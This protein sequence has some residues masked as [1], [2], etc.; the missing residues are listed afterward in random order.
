MSENVPSGGLAVTGGSRGLANI[1][2]SP[3]GVRSFLETWTGIR[4][5]SGPVSVRYFRFMCGAT[6]TSAEDIAEN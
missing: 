5:C 3:E 6:M 4:S 1:S 2:D